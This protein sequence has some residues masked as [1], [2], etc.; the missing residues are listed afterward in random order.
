MFL[1]AKVT[2]IIDAAAP[3]LRVAVLVDG[4]TPVRTTLES[5]PRPER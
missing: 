3:E 4:V 2:G 5:I 1:G